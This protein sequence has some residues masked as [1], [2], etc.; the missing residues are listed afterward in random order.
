MKPSV[1][2]KAAWT[3]LTA[4]VTSVVGVQSEMHGLNII[5]DRAM[6]IHEDFQN[7]NTGSFYECIWPLLF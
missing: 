3:E 2:R 7:A 4:G 6:C 5:D 1:C